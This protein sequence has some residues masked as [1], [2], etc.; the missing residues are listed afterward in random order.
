VIASGR[1][2]SPT[3]LTDTSHT[4]VGRHAPSRVIAI[5]TQTTESAVLSTY[6]SSSTLAAPS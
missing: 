4:T 2:Y 1:C 5:V 6:V 3:T